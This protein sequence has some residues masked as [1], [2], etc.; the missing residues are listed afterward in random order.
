M[1][2]KN[3]VIFQPQILLP[4]Q[5]DEAFMQRWSVIA[6]DQFTSD[7]KYWEAL[8]QTVGDNP[9]TLRLV[10]PEVYLKDADGDQRIQNINQTMQ[11]Y[12]HDGIF[13]KLDKGFVLTERTTRFTDQKRYG[14]VLAVDLE[15][16]SFAPKSSA[17]IRATEATVPERIPPRVKIRRDAKLELPH[18]MLLYNAPEE[19]ILGDIT[20][21]T[22]QPALYDF[23]LNQA[24]GHLKGWFIDEEKS[25][26]VMDKLY[27]TAGEMLFAVGDGNHSL[28][29]AKTCWEDIK[30]DLSEEERKIHPARF[31]LCEA[32]SIYSK[33]L[34]F[35]PI[36]R[37]VLG[38]D[39]EQFIQSVKKSVP[40]P[41]IN[42]A[43]VLAFSGEYDV[44]QALRALDDCI[45]A[46]LKAN[47]GEVDYIHGDSELKA[48]VA[49]N[50]NSVGIR[51]NAISKDGFFRSVEEGGSLPRKTFSMGEGAEKRY[52][53]ECKE[54]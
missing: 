2:E 54:I 12:L 14:I 22:A 43:N 18:V 51:L 29:T 44:A 16:Y 30:K 36:H 27:A 53:T 34:T 49:E 31:A 17:A 52:Y 48:L 41:V 7:R 4:R 46:Y 42:E 40:M 21:F 6:C 45:A 25:K 39:A 32:V 5:T 9:S 15:A 1:H 13:Q 33:A 19:Q 28:A 37:F 23:E 24:G 20:C 38:V 50:K 26:T 10:F 47:G 11:T 3:K 8:N 35:E